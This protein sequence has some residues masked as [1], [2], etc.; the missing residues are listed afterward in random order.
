MTSITIGILQGVVITKPI[1]II[2]ISVL[3]AKYGRRQKVRFFLS[4]V[5]KGIGNYVFYY[6]LYRHSPIFDK[7]KKGSF[8]VSTKYILG[9]FN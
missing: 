1:K 5:D 7:N 2:L 3:M 9:S 8:F 4:I 6:R